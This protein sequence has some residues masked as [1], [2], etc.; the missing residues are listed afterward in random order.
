[1]LLG[2]LGDKPVDRGGVHFLVALRDFTSLTQCPSPGGSTIIPS[3]KTVCLMGKCLSCSQDE[4]DSTLQNGHTINSSAQ[5]SSTSHNVTTTAMIKY[6]PDPPPIPAQ[7]PE[8]GDASIPLAHC[9]RPPSITDKKLFNQYH[10]L[11]P[12]RKPSNGGE[13]KRTSFTLGRDYSESKINAL[14]DIYKDPDED[15][16]LADGIEKFCNDLEV[17]PEEF[18]VLVL[19]WKFQ[20][21]TMCKFTRAEMVQGCKKLHVDSIKGIQ[22]RFPDLLEEVRD[23][24]K[25]K[26]LYRWTYKFGLD[27]EAGQRTL[28][29]DMAV[30]L[31]QLV[32]SERQPPILKQWLSFLDIH[33]NVRGIPR[34][35]WDMFLNFVEA[36]GDDLSSYDDTEAWPSLFDDF[37]EYENDRQNQNVKVEKVERDYYD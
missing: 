14:F 21:E 3:T 12:I 5:K 19:A 15:A 28:P 27:S 35:T 24:E 6:R 37:V 34:D 29:V 16:I 26:D 25:F 33:H 23:K 1:M 2:S 18:K 4:D 32:F 7:L 30:S 11:P 10:K 31:W 36:V 13:A 17:Q 9:V 8:A 22:S 20:A